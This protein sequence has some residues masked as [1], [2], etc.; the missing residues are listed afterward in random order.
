MRIKRKCTAVIA[1]ILIIQLIC[2]NMNVVFGEMTV[3]SSETELYA[4]EAEAVTA[5]VLGDDFFANEAVS[6]A[7]FTAAIV[8]AMKMQGDYKISYSDVSAE[9]GFYKEICAA[10]A[11]GLISDAEV[12]EPD[13]PISA[14]QAIKMLVCAVGYG[15]MADALGGWPTG[16]IAAA[17]RALL[18]EGISA[19]EA[20]L[21]VQSAKRL[22]YNILISEIMPSSV[23]DGVIYYKDGGES[24]LKT[25]Y[26]ISTASGI[27][28]ETNY[29]SFKAESAVEDRGYINIE[30]KTLMYAEATPE[31]LGANVY[32][33]YN[34]E[35][36]EVM[37]LFRHNNQEVRAAK[38][39]IKSMTRNEIV[40][41][42]SA[43]REKSIDISGA[44]FMYNGRLGTFTDVTSLSGDY[45]E[46]RLLDNNNDNKYEYV[47]VE[48]YRYVLADRIDYVKKTVS[49]LNAKSVSGFVPKKNGKYFIT[50]SQGEE[51]EFDDLESGILLAIA[52]S[53]DGELIRIK[54]SEE[55]VSGIIESVKTD[56]VKIGEKWFYI[57]EYAKKSC[58]ELIVA[59]AEGSFY[60]GLGDDI[61]ASSF[62]G[63]S[64]KY[65]YLI[66]AAFETKQLSGSAK[67]K[68]YT[69]AA[70]IEIFKAKKVF[71]DDEKV[72]TKDSAIV[73]RLKTGGEVVPQMIRYSLDAEGNI[74]RIDLAE[75]GTDINEVKSEN[76]SLKKYTF[77]SGGAV[78]NSFLYRSTPA[79]CMPYFNLSSSIIFGIPQ[80][81]EIKSADET[82]FIVLNRSSLISGRTYTMD[83][84]DLDENGCAGAAVITDYNPENG[85]FYMYSQ[86]AM[87][88]SVETC[89]LADET[90]GTH[91][92]VYGTSGYRE[93]YFSE[94]RLSD[95]GGHLAA[96]DIIDV[97][98]D[99]SGVVRA[100]AKVMSLTGE[101]P[102]RE[103]SVPSAVKFEDKGSR[104][105]WYGYLYSNGGV[106]GYITKDK[107]N[108]SIN[109]LI[110]V[111][112][113]AKNIAVI[114]KERNEIRKISANELK[115]KRSFG[116]GLYYVVL[117][118]D[119]QNPQAV[120][121][122]EL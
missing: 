2:A 93:L 70:S 107:N 86:P 98:A 25:L 77:T 60:V 56:K 32:A 73:D 117:F 100:V 15:Y 114:N 74:S 109:D 27:V 76:N 47:F 64:M 66:D 112:L 45:I 92:Y 55:M 69:Q 63:S 84:Y 33:Y 96:G 3:E 89:F 71:F 38:T 34:D 116:D 65:G 24:N 4:A 9:H 91:A 54:T 48:N 11:N 97:V 102:V 108:T 104:S 44:R 21:N 110:N 29:N 22:I 106:Y 101:I 67:I 49:D 87:V 85:G 13:S 14:V 72:A 105:Y 81:S 40:C 61:A 19:G 18:S 103:A 88:E 23:E 39:D 20:E 50:N 30:G 62:K 53:A 10:R 31:L 41:Y 119:A 99:E 36:K 68:I 118:L 82:K 28:Y 83:V 16:Y 95:I 75:A 115:D 121:A 42:N 35:T 17:K 111:K 57:S 43:G 7:E 78:V 120:F 113:D 37:F 46:V 122:Y 52:E 59:G 5:Y 58:K 94:E 51:I 26:N 8:R 79:S 90:I 1:A 80:G 6:R 12:F